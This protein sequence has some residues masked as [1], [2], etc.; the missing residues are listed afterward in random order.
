MKSDDKKN[1]TD[2]FAVSLIEY[3]PNSILSK[4]IMKKYTGSVILSSV[5]TGESIKE[6][7]SAFDIFIQIIEGTAEVIIR[8]K[9]Y[10]MICGNG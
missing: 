7:I 2:Q 3:L 10:M 9:S 5:D 1:K 4:I 8:K 6:K